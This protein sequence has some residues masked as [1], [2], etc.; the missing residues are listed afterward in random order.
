[1]RVSSTSSAD[2][3]EMKFMRRPRH[4]EKGKRLYDEEH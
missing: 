1:M 2:F 3:S 4:A